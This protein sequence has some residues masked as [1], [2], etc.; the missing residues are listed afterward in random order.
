MTMV[1]TFIMDTLLNKM[2]FTL[3]LGLQ[4]VFDSGKITYQCIHVS[5]WQK[6]YC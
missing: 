6:Y 3:I 4:Y 2:L 5:N 1:V